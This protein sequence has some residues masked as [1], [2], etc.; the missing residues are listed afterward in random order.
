MNHVARTPPITSLFGISVALALLGGVMACLWLPWL[1][2]WWLSLVLLLAG[3]AGWANWPALSLRTMLGDASRRRVLGAFLC[4]FAWTGLHGAHALAVQ[5]PSSLEKQETIVTGRI[6]D[7]PEHEPRRTRF[8]F[9]VDAD[10]ARRP[11]LQGRT[12]RL[13]WYDDEHREDASRP[14][15]GLKAG[16]RWSLPVRLR[17]PRGLRNPGGA[18]AEKFAMAQRLTA[19]GYVYAPEMAQ[20]LSTAHGLE[21]WREAMSARIARQVASP[22]SRFIRAL[23]LG[24]TRAL[25]D[26]DWEALR[27]NGLT[28]LIAIS[29]FHVGLVAGFFALIVRGMWWLWPA[30]ARRWPLP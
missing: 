21:A 30:L 11:E 9:E 5:L 26:A 24:D 27:A 4:G 22:S 10:G 29:G 6:V 23:A 19:T 12:L 20:R 17:A 3:C 2:P 7:L 14:R 15:F 18:D 8:L 25:G 1:A 28:H 13:A 16:Q